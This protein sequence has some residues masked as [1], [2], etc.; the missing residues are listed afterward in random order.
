MIKSDYFEINRD[1]YSIPCKL[2]Y[3]DSGRLNEIK[4]LIVGVHGFAGDKESSVLSLLAENVCD[5]NTALLCFDFPAHGS[6][7]ASDDMLSVKNCVSDVVSV[8]K[9]ARSRFYGACLYAFATSF[10]AYVTLLSL[11][12]INGRFEKIVLRAPA[13]NMAEVLLKRVLFTDATEFKKRGTI[14]CGFERKI[15]LNFAFYEGLLNN[16]IISRDFE[17]EFLI[18][19]GTCDDLVLPSD[20]EKF[21]RSNPSSKLVFIE[22]A[23]HRFKKRGETEKVLEIATTYFNFLPDKG[24]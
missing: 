4:N 11:E 13:V 1:A 9:W 10:G 12:Q 3:K 19:H 15:N 8:V 7:E 22:G 18:I 2:Y 6:S 17:T 24:E 21:A 16:D 23:D 14:S 20:V 5:V